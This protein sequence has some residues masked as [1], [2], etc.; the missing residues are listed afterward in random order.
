M[1]TAQNTIR[2]TSVYTCFV[3]NSDQRPINSGHVKDLMSSMGTFGFLPSKP[4]QVY[5]D[6]KKF[7]II[8]GHHRYIA[9][10][11]LQ[12]P[13]LYVVEPKSHQESIASGNRFQNKWTAANFV[14]MY[15]NRGLAPYKELKEYAA[16]G[17]PLTSAASML[18]GRSSAARGGSNGGANSIFDGTLQIKT[19]EKI[20]KI[21]QFLRD[22]GNDNKAY[23]THNF[24][25]SA[26]LCMRLKDFDFSQLSAKL[27]ANPRMMARTATVD[28]ML[29]QIEEIYNYHQRIRT[30]IAFPAKECKKV[31]ESNKKGSAK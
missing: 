3:Y 30:P 15:A 2:E 4:V 21:A 17:I 29:D 10:K 28:Q 7:V 19:R 26:E 20:E 6:G 11:N 13:V 27:A 5:Q 1:K 14:N 16:L 8:D 12:I 9:A 18:T 22:Y 25:V 24:I 31:K 23:K